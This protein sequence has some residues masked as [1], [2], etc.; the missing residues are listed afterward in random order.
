[1]KEATLPVSGG[2]MP[3][4]ECAEVMAQFGYEAVKTPGA[5]S[6]SA[7]ARVTLKLV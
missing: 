4:D 6:T 2:R 3:D 7:R 5:A 1:M